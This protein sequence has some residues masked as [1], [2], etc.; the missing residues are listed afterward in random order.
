M[1]MGHSALDWITAVSAAA[2]AIGT[3]A[4]VVTALYLS[5]WREARRR[6]TL[7]LEL[8][9]HS[10]LIGINGRDDDLAV[11]PPYVRGR[12]AV[13]S[14]AIIEATAF[15]SSRKASTY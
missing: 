6:P 1:Q 5:L 15:S 10:D 13:S 12:R 7:T 9:P 11:E 3:V 2:G 14:E 8:A 4:A